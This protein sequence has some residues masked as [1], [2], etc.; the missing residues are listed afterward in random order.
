MSSKIDAFISEVR[1]RPGFVAASATD[2]N[3][4]DQLAAIERLLYSIDRMA[5]DDPAILEIFDKIQEV[6]GRRDFAT[7]AKLLDLGRLLAQVRD[8]IK[9]VH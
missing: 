7:K 9:F 4:I 2:S 6:I 1:C 5:D 8:T 3:W